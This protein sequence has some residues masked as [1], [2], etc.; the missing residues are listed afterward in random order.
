MR[1][2]KWI[3]WF[4]LA[5]VSC[6]FLPSARPQSG[7]SM[8]QAHQAWSQVSNWVTYYGPYYDQS[9]RSQL[10]SYDLLVLGYMDKRQVIP[11]QP[12]VLQYLAVME[13]SPTARQYYD[14]LKQVD[15][16][17]HVADNP[18]YPGTWI[19]DI[20]QPAWRDKI[21][22]EAIPWT[23]SHGGN[24]L[25]LDTFGD[26]DLYVY[27]NDWLQAAALL[28]RDIRAA[29]PDLLLVINEPG[30]LLYQVYPQIDGFI[31]EQFQ[32]DIR[33]GQL[34][35]QP[36]G[37]WG[38]SDF[39]KFLQWRQQNSDAQRLLV[40]T[41]DMVQNND[42]AKIQY[43]VDQSLLY[44]FVPSITPAS[45]LAHRYQSLSQQLKP[46]GH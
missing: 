18:D 24:G 31:W 36:R 34:L 7:L 33:S 37:S 1:S 8:Q 26:L 44:G 39:H 13:A 28:V 41:N 3:S 27:G 21:I 4:I 12:I 30:Q 2:F 23:L 35:S 17:W 20:R 46:V 29:Y 10:N 42:P 40:L 6:S 45:D 9:M 38:N 15:P 19:M 25:M 11:H 16:T 43:C 5:L 32:A 14:W 22:K